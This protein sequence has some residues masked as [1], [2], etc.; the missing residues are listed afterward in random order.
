[1]WTCIFCVKRYF[2]EKASMSE[3]NKMRREKLKYLFDASNFITTFSIQVSHRL[4]DVDKLL[5]FDRETKKL[6]DK[7]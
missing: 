4:F 2:K 5:A 1:M 6:V 3:M 7:P